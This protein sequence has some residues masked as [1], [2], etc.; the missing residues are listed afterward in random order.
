MKIKNRIFDHSQEVT[1]SGLRSLVD[2]QKSAEIFKNEILKGKS[3]DSKGVEKS[4]LIE[5]VKVIEDFSEIIFNGGFDIETQ[6]YLDLNELSLK[7][8]DFLRGGE[9]ESDKLSK[10]FSLNS[11]G[12]VVSQ[13]ITRLVTKLDSIDLE[14]WQ[15]VSRELIMEEGSVIYNVV[16]SDQGHS[17]SRIAE[18]G[19]YNS[20]KLDS[21]EDYIKTSGGKVG[22]K[23][24]YSEEAA[25]RAGVVAIR[26][27]AEAAVADIKKFKTLEAL[28]LLEAN[29]HTY[30]DALDEAKM[31]SGVSYVTPSK[32]NGT[33]L[34]RDMEKFF[35]DTQNK[36]FE[37]DV[38]FLNPLALPIFMNEPAIKEHLE[39][40]ANITFIIPKKNKT[41]AQN[42]FTKMTKITSNSEKAAEGQSFDI[43]SNLIKNKN[44]N[45]IV[46]PIANFHAEGSTII[47]PETRYSKAPQVGHKEAPFACAD[48]LLVDSSRALTFVHDGRGI[49]SDTIVNKLRDVTDIKFK[50]YYHFLL[51]KDHGVFAFRNMR[52]TDDVFDPK[53]KL[54]TTISHSDLY[55]TPAVPGK[56][57][58][59]TAPGKQ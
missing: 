59:T 25:K 46:T 53:Q 58:K 43:P 8:E 28:H 49:M 3:T 55:P 57:A 15:F 47:K 50:T 38:V 29:A 21:T 18:G 45:V 33:L 9:K 26:M 6:K 35:S 17:T 52:I 7:M 56:T 22:V 44:L 51:D 1:K 54:I 20:F 10:D 31:P 27:L 13:T 2:A 11:L 23:A 48:L 36:G 14:A 41:I 42:M 34:M 40:T 24:S 12:F 30:Y 4:N 32:K 39:K 16:I 37:I 19:E 5:I